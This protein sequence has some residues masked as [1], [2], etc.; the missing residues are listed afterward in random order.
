MREINPHRAYADRGGACLLK[1]A[2]KI[3]GLSRQAKS[4]GCLGQGV[5]TLLSLRQL[6][7]TI[8]ESLRRRIGRNCAPPG[9]RHSKHG[10]N[11]E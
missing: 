1:I 5:A 10:E 3:R 8:G 7:V 4:S 2:F 6:A 9:G 11:L